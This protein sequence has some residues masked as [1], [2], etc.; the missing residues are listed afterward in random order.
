MGPLHLAP[1]TACTCSS[2]LQP[3]LLPEAMACM[4]S[5]FPCH[6]ERRA[7]AGA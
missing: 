2:G 3:V 4:P 1:C 7:G 6:A 5:L